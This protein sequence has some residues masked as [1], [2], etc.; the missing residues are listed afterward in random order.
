[1]RKIACVLAAI[2]AMQTPASASTIPDRYS[3]YSLSAIRLVSARFADTGEDAMDK[4]KLRSW[5]IE[6][7]SLEF[8]SSGT[9]AFPL[10]STAWPW[11]RNDPGQPLAVSTAVL[12]YTDDPNR[13][14]PASQYVSI[15]P[16]F[17]FKPRCGD[18]LLALENGG[19]AYPELIPSLEEDVREFCHLRGDALLTFD[20]EVVNARLD[21][22]MAAGYDEWAG[23]PREDLFG[24]PKGVWSGTGSF[25]IRVPEGNRVYLWM[26]ASVAGVTQLRP[27][28]APPTVALML[29]LLPLWGGWL[30]WRRA[31]Q[32]G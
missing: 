12:K 32:R 9:P 8:E 20:Y 2:V 6:Y 23:S 21:G 18:A 14:G 10:R 25:V 11:D 29:A 15:F 22:F 7:D 27:V 1:M 5:G 4:I 13:V 19:E 24:G 31:A 28:P 17:D 16:T 26:E 3:D 30:A